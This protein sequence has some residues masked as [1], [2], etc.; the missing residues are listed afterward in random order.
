MAGMVLELQQLLRDR[1][2][3]A[4][5]VL[6]AVSFLGLVSLFGLTASDAPMALVVHDRGPFVRPFVEALVKVPHAFRLTRM[7]A[8]EADAKL[9]EGVLVGSIVIP[10]HFSE[11][12]ASG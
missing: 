11:A 12:I 8:A 9:A 7:T 3:V 1:A 4:L 2:Y 5:T 10:A 6:A